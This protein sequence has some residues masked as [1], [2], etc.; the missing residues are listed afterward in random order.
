[1]SKVSVVAESHSQ[2]AL[3]LPLTTRQGGRVA[4]CEE[5]G[6]PPVFPI[7]EG[8][9][10]PVV[11]WGSSKVCAVSAIRRAER[12]KNIPP[13]RE[14]HPVDGELDLVGCSAEDL[15]VAL[16]GLIFFCFLGAGLL[17]S[18]FL[19]EIGRVSRWRRCCEVSRPREGASG[20]LDALHNK[21]KRNIPYF[22]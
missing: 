8:P 19:L 20:L 4:G 17:N 18:W 2:L 15:G 13:K 11:S 16:L 10:M 22:P 14:G 21:S 1:M 6:Q 9:V 5:P 3:F 12:P 7:F